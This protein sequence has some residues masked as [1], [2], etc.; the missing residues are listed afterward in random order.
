M[1]ARWPVGSGIRI[2]ENGHSRKYEDWI[3]H[4][5]TFHENT[6][7]MLVF[8]RKYTNTD[9]GTDEYSTA[10]IDGVKIYNRPLSD[11]EVLAMYNSNENEY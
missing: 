9:T 7:Y 6:D 10:L 5:S 2:F 1:T 11:T 3:Q 4:A 8:G